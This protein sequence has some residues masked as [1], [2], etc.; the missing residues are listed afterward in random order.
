MET[1]LVT[2]VICPKGCSISVNWKEENGH[3]TV[4]EVNGNSCKRGYTYASSEVIH[5]V[6]VLSS[7]VRIR[8]SNLSL[9]PVRS[10][11]PI[12]KEVLLEAMKTIKET[13]VDAP[14]RMGDV[15]IRNIASTG[16]D[17]V[18]CRDAERK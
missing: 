13:T 8:G 4:I 3:K 18:A 1:S 2:C 7:T 6:R 12:P 15:I 5:P 14:L 10:A 16:V 11:S 17:M 9:L